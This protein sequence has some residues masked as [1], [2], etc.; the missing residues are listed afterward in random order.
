[1]IAALGSKPRTTK[2]AAGRTPRLR[3]SGDDGGTASD[4]GRYRPRDPSR[5]RGT[6]SDAFYRLEP[7]RITSGSGLGLT[8]VVAVADLHG[9]TVTLAGSVPGLR[10]MVAFQSDKPAS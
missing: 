7:S 3:I 2:P 9:A 6:S 5:K 8:L 4:G 10:V 1:M